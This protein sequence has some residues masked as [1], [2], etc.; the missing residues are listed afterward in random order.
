MKILLGG[1]MKFNFKLLSIIFAPFI[2]WFIFVF[3]VTIGYRLIVGE[4]F[5]WLTGIILSI[6]SFIFFLAVAIIIYYYLGLFNYIFS[7]NFNVEEKVKEID[8]RTIRKY[9]VDYFIKDPIKPVNL[10][11]VDF[12][13]SGIRSVGATKKTEIYI[14]KFRDG[15]Y[16]KLVYYY[17]GVRVNNLTKTY[18]ETR[19]YNPSQDE[20]EMLV[21]KICNNLAESP[22]QTM[23]T[24]M[25]IIQTP[26]GEEKVR[27]ERIP[28]GTKKTTEESF[29]G[30]DF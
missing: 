1:I 20:E 28:F 26:F 2:I 6:V 4:F 11:I 19:K 23:E 10:Q 15:E 29:F 3:I 12:N 25:K 5:S 14:D 18:Y 24:E 21:K 8:P 16:G 9:L 27:T 30:D 17:V 13:F 7:S 22:E